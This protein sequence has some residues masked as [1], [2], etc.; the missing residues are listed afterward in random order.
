MVRVVQVTTSDPREAIVSMSAN[1]RSNPWHHA[2]HGRG[3]RTTE[4]VS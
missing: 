4:E 3:N 2:C 1:V